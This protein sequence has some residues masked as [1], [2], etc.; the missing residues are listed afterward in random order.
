MP[1][2]QKAEIQRMAERIQKP[3]PLV[4]W[5]VA[6]APVVVDEVYDEVDEVD[7]DERKKMSCSISEERVREI[8]ADSNRLRSTTAA[9]QDKKMMDKV[10]AEIAKTVKKL[11]ADSK[12][13]KK[14]ERD[15]L[16][17]VV[18]VEK[19]ARE[20][21]VKKIV[22]EMKKMKEEVKEEMKKIK[23]EAKDEVK[24]LKEETAELKR[25]VDELNSLAAG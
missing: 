9:T 24:K 21:A 2:D 5:K 6:V 25:Q 17:D 1:E 15:R 14:E 4:K 19:A 18:L 22:D 12:R 13:E 8:I 20:D 11:A 7:E 23:D 3:T 16:E 10:D